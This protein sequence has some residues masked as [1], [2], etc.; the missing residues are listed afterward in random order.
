MVAV[1][2]LAPLLGTVDPARID[3][4]YRNKLPMSERTITMASG[5]KETRTYLMG[6]DSLGRDVYSRVVYGARISLVVGVGVAAISVAIGLVIGLVSGYIRWLDGIVMRFMDGMMAIPGILLAIALV[7][8]WGAGLA[9]VVI[10][11]VVP[12][13]PRVVRLVR[14]VVL[15]IREEP[16]VEAA[17]SVGTPTPLILIRHVLPNTIAPLIVQGTYI[18]AFAILVEAILSFLGIGIPPQIPTWGNIM[19]EGRTLFRVFPHNILF[20]GVFLALTVLAV[21]MLGDGLRD[22]LDPRMS[23]RV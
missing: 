16:Y 15:T 7:S 4:T 13:I 22:T 2:L 3:P 5:A 17:I 21:N 23:K 1:A 20:P 14:S 8:V 19:A 12:E 11:I 18:C 9:T 6:T 10:A